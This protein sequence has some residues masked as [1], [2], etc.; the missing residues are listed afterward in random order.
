MKGLRFTVAM[1]LAL[2]ALALAPATSVFANPPAMTPPFQSQQTQT[3]QAPNPDEHFAG[4][5]VWLNGNRYILRDDVNDT[6]Y[7]LDDQKT[8]AKYLGKKVNVTGTLDGRSDVI[9]VR[10]IHPVSKT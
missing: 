10:S 6:W 2:A 9:H 5:I 3:T 7:H 1:G 4:V 8:A